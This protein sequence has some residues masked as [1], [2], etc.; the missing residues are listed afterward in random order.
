M[1]GTAIEQVIGKKRTAD[2]DEEEE[3]EKPVKK[4]RSGEA[5]DVKDQF[6]HDLFDESVWEGYTQAY[7]QSQP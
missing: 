6:R 7:A 4:Q 3:V 1:D 2:E 5:Q